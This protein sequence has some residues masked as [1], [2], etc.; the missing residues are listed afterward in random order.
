[1]VDG[2]I[3]KHE[4]INMLICPKNHVSLGS[5]VEIPPDGKEAALVL[6][7]L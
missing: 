5:D 3:Q 4:M 1:M 2:K 7:N 6:M